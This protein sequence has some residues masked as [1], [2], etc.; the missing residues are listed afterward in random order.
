M[1]TYII[2]TDGKKKSIGQLPGSKSLAS[3]LDLKG[4]KVGATIQTA[5]A[6]ELRILR[7]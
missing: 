4:R 3:A 2:K 5:D 1:L 7:G 6:A